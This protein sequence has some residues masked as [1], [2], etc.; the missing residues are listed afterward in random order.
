ML[1]NSITNSE[2]LSDRC[3]ICD[4]GYLRQLYRKATH[5]IGYRCPGEPV[6]QYLAKGGHPEETEG[7]QCLCNGLLATIGLGQVR[8]NSDELP[9]V[10]AGE[11]ALNLSR[12]IQ[13]DKH[14][15]ADDV[16]NSLLNQHID[17]HVQNFSMAIDKVRIP[18]N[19]E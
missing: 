5:Q 14:Y 13:G 10:T 8:K 15:S 9:L 19:L 1:E 6:K 16:I 18:N 17:G 3:R 7:K 11:E 4:L 2:A 12:F